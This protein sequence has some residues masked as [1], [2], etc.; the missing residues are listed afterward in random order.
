MIIYYTIRLL[1]NH[2]FLSSA[3]RHL[4]NVDALDR[5]VNPCAVNAVTCYFLNILTAVNDAVDA[6]HRL[7]HE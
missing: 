1:G 5:S 7:I 2:D 6:F 3:V 4:D